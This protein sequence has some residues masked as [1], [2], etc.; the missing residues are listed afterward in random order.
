MADCGIVGF[1]CGHYATEEPGMEVLAVALQKAFPAV[2]CNVRVY[3]SVAPAYGFP[4]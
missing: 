2:E 4:R 3:V 1:E